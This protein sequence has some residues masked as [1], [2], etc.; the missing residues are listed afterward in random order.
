[1]TKIR[2][3]VF[4]ACLFF[5]SLLGFFAGEFLI[6][7]PLPEV[8]VPRVAGLSETDGIRILLEAGLEPETRAEYPADL[9]PGTILR[10]DPAEGQLV[11]LGRK[12]RVDVASSAPSLEVPALIGRKIEEAEVELA[13]LGAGL[14]VPIGLLCTIHETE[15]A[16]TVAPGTILAQSPNAGTRL[17]AGSRIEIL[18]AYAPED[19]RVAVPNLQGRSYDEAES[20]LVSAG[21]AVGEVRTLPFA[22]AS[23]TIYAT[24]PPMGR[25]VARGTHVD[26]TIAGTVSNPRPA[27][28]R[29]SLSYTIPDTAPPGE[30]QI[31]LRDASGEREVWHGKAKPKDVISTEIEVRAGSPSF[32]VV[33]DG[34]KVDAWEL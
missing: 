14:G 9:P 11:R 20:I 33:A 13:R 30:Y 19:T 23:G 29:V 34:K 3:L 1:M 8:R 25:R 15:A 2:L 16:P 6:V 12:V 4:L 32:R 18:G 7:D 31:F 10:T 28:R 21:L 5:L 17:P 24:D 27:E 26:L 22:A